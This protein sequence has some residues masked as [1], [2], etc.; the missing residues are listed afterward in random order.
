MNRA[1]GLYKTL[2]K[3]N[4]K[5]IIGVPEKE[6]TQEVYVQQEKKHLKKYWHKTSQ[7]KCKMLVFT[8]KKLNKLS[9]L[10][11]KR[12]MPNTKKIKLSKDK[13]NLESCN[14]EEILL[15]QVTV[16]PTT[17]FSSETMEARDSGIK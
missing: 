12:T 16:I 17:D 1:S 4:N 15:V 8:F 14:K 5:C 6:D 11:F 10:T 2:I 13:D 7:T 3:H 9:R